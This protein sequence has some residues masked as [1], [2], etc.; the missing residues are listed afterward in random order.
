MRDARGTI[1]GA[2]KIARGI[3]GRKC[4]EMAALLCAAGDTNAALT[5]ER[6]RNSLAQQQLAQC[7]T[8]QRRR[9]TPR[10]RVQGEERDLRQ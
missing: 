2:S 4:M 3:G 10:V 5:P 8:A 1:I 7:L 9:A 6:M